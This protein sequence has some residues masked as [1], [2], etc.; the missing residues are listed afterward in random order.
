MSLSIR[1]PNCGA[2]IGEM[3][4]KNNYQQVYYHKGDNGQPI[5]NNC[6]S[7]KYDNMERNILIFAVVFVAAVVFS[8]SAL[9]IRGCIWYPYPKDFSAMHF[10][11]KGCFFHSSW[12][13]E[14]NS[15][16]Y[17]KHWPCRWKKDLILQGSRKFLRILQNS[18]A[19][20]RHLQ[21]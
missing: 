2:I 16:G 7:G 17:E 15:Q 11:K 18:S 21:D 19:G 10:Y 4:S 3:S 8:S 6:G 12:L 13:Q 20:K 9:H 14:G 5:C 1:C